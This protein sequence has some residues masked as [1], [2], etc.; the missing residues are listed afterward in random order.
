M[1]IL[2][3]SICLALIGAILFSLIGLISGTD[4]TAIMVPFTLLVIL[5]GAPP[6]AV[7]AFFMAAVLAKHLTHA[8]P[9]ALMGIP[10]DT[11]AV[12]LID[13]ASA[14]RRLGMPHI[15]LRKMVS[16]GVIGAFIALPTAVLLGQFLGQFAD[17][18]KSASGL[19][20][21]LAAILI[22]FFSKGKWVSVLMIIPLAFF[23][24][25]LDVLSFSILDKHLTISFFLGIA[26]GPMFTD[27]LFALSGNARQ[28]IQR[29]RPKEYHLAPDNKSW[30]GF[31]PNP[32]KILTK[33]QTMQTTGTSFISSLTF[34]FSPVG[35]TSLMGEIVGSRSKGIYKKSTSSLTTM[36]GVTESTYIAEAIIPLIAF[37]IPLSPVA[38]GP[39]SP[40]F[41]APP[42]FTSDPVN[43][44]HNY[45]DPLDFLLYGAIGLIIATLIAYPFSMNYARK[46]T[47]LVMRFISQEAIVAM[48]IGLA[49]LLAFHEAGLVGIVL[50]FTMAAIG[51]LLNKI[52]GIGSGVQFMVFYASA[53]LISVLFGF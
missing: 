49:C 48:F 47:V 7:F 4:E 38:L 27:I 2:L 28:T 20:F 25:S 36:N 32:F 52:L 42:V 30:A 3:I 34:V 12:P 33:R 46:A 31:F 39:A 8:V 1:S 44:L 9:T 5:L 35:M 43:N 50:T 53:W 37:G 17:F 41:N 23:I 51:G 10:G 40:L 22:A 24:K 19:I 26:I 18:F 16:G 14:L 21:T 15:A 11:T 13:H 6:A 45:L 29:D